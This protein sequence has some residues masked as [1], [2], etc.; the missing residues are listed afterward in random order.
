MSSLSS[1]TLS[2]I[3]AIGGPRRSF[4]VMARDGDLTQAM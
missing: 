3:I 1:R 2:L 4:A